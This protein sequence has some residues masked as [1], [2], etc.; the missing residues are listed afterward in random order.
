MEALSFSNHS[1]HCGGSG[2]KSSCLLC[3]FIV[4]T[5]GQSTHTEITSHKKDI[6][7]CYRDTKGQCGPEDRSHTASGYKKTCH[8]HSCLPM[9]ALG[10]GPEQLCSVEVNSQESDFW[11]QAHPTLL[12]D[13]QQITSPLWVP[14]SSPTKGKVRLDQVFKL[15][16]LQLQASRESTENRDSHFH[17]L[18]SDTVI[19]LHIMFLHRLS[20]DKRYHSLKNK[21]K[22][23]L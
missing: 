20:L 8:V 3:P 15:C 5:C 6:L 11:S 7:V 2:P 23:K 10:H 22:E 9:L 4:S 16:S 19:C 14:V 1:A 12:G 21:T 13:L 18:H 17:S